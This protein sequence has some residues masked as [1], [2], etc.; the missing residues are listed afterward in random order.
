[1]KR[2]KETLYDREMRLKVEIKDAQDKITRQEVIIKKLRKMNMEHC[3]Y[4]RELEQRLNAFTELFDE[5]D[6]VKQIKQKGTSLYYL[7]F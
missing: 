5:K 4:E 3:D 1:M 7:L 6:I 2:K